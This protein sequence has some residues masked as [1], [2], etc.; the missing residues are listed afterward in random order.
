MV[1]DAHFPLHL[2][3]TLTNAGDTE[4]RATLGFVYCRE[5]N[6]GACVM[7]TFR[8]IV[9]IQVAPDGD[10]ELLIDQVLIPELPEPTQTLSNVKRET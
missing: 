3:L 6:E 7:K 2:P 5:G 9:P 4:V 8:W 10:A 1:K